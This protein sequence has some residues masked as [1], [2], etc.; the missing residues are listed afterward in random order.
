MVI[1]Q[2]P[3]DQSIG[4]LAVDQDVLRNRGGLVGQ[5]VSIGCKAAAPAAYPPSPLGLDPDDVFDEF[6]PTLDDET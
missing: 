4:L 5:G 1:V 3:V 6:V 2:E